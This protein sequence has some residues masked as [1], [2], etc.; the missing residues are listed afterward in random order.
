[1]KKIAY[2]LLP[3]TVLA[4]ASC[5]NSST[6]PATTDSVSTTTVA[7]DSNAARLDTTN[8]KD[9]AN[10]AVNAADGGMLEVQLGE[11]A[12]KNG[13]SAAVKKFGQTM[14]DDHSKINDEL[15]ALAPKENMTL[16]TSLSDKSQKKYNDLAKETGKDFDKDYTNA[17][18]DAHKTD[19]DAFQKESD[20]GNDS[21]LKTW[22][23]QKLPTLQGHLQMAKDMKDKM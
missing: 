21:A 12:V 10:F 4:I 1:M 17:M 8:L 7:K 22:T 15:K 2:W 5:N 23:T 16:P 6:T 9:D 18:I 11:L 3:V 13:S 20:K 14:V 19:I